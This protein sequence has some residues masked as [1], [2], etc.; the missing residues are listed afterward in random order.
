MSRWFCAYDAEI[1]PALLLSIFTQGFGIPAFCKEVG[2]SR[3]AF[4]RWVSANPEFGAAYGVAKECRAHYFEERMLDAIDS[5]EVNTQVLLAAAKIMGGQGR[6]PLELRGFKKDATFQEHFTCLLNN[7]GE[8]NVDVQEASAFATILTAGVK[9]YEST[10]ME[11]RVTRLE[12]EVGIEQIHQVPA[13]EAGE[14]GDT[15]DD[16]LIYTETL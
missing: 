15:P 5:K 1:H 9:I 14:E 16:H 11:E 4:Y 7:I 13:S 3:A 8:S 12:Q 10:V 2:I 6:A